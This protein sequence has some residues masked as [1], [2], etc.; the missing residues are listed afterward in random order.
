MSIL[1][2]EI[3]SNWRFNSR[4]GVFAP[5][6]ITAEEQ[7]VQEFQEFAGN[8]G[9]TLNEVP[10]ISSLS[11]TEVKR[12]SDSQIFTH[13]TNASVGNTEYFF[14]YG[15]DVPILFFNSI[16]DG[17]TFLVK[18][19]GVGGAVNAKNLLSIASRAGNFETRL[20]SLIRTNPFNKSLT[21]QN[22][23][24]YNNWAVVNNLSITGNCEIRTNNP[25][26]VGIL[27]ILG[28]L[29][30]SNVADLKI[31]R[32]ILLIHGSIKIPAGTAT[33]S[34]P[35]GFAGGEGYSH[36]PTSGVVFYLGGGGAGTGQIGANPNIITS[37]IYHIAGNGG[38]SRIDQASQTNAS[39]AIFQPAVSNYHAQAGGIGGGGGGGAATGG[40]YSSN[41]TIQLNSAS[42]GIGGGGG[43]GGGGFLQAIGGPGDGTFIFA[44]ASGGAGSLFHGAGGHG[45]D[46]IA[47]TGGTAS[48]QGGG[49]GGGSGGSGIFIFCLGTISPDLTVISGRGGSYGAGGSVN[50]TYGQ[51]GDITVYSKYTGT[52][53]GTYDTALAG[54]GLAGSQNFYKLGSSSDMSIFEIN[55]ILY[56][57][58]ALIHGSSAWR[59]ADKISVSI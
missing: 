16:N 1:E 25:D 33:I 53:P 38:Y 28:D 56:K 13:T 2:G 42:G 40:V 45:G 19:S 50:A 37:E 29:Y 49:G 34:A 46:C 6:S 26:S 21:N 44:G 52:P 24:L 58:L 30:L 9:F 35:D 31:C 22:V 36:N 12:V 18:Y 17:E 10:D 55:T 8:Y 48:G 54:N 39:G 51:S 32:V 4:T 15:N 59:I 43:G 57:E 27:E 41:I 3:D 47:Y 14:D 23:Y 20:Q 7:L 5:V 11:I